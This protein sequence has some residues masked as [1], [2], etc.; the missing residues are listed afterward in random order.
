MKKWS[1]WITVAW[2]LLNFIQIIITKDTLNVFPQ[3]NTF[4][5]YRWLWEAKQIV[6]YTCK[7]I[8]VFPI[9]IL[10]IVF[11]LG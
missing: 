2:Y 3:K 7:R 6:N 9:I 10:S 11:Y 4:G 8:L 5:G 1:G